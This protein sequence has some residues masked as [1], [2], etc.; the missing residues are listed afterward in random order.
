MQ[1]K[2]FSYELG[3]PELRNTIHIGAGISF[4]LPGIESTYTARNAAHTIILYLVP[5]PFLGQY[6]M[7]SILAHLILSFP[8]DVTQHN[9]DQQ[10]VVA[11]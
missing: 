7:L 11:L 10:S 6:G 1:C 9:A 5:I 4:G 3:K 2:N 8:H